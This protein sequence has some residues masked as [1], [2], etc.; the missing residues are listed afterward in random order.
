LRLSYYYP[1]TR[2][3]STVREAGRWKYHLG[4]LIFVA[5]TAVRNTSISWLVKE[6]EPLYL[7]FLSAFFAA[8]FSASVRVSNMGWRIPYKVR[9]RAP[10]FLGLGFGTLMGMAGTTLTLT[11]LSPVLTSLFDVAVYPATVGVL[12]WLLTHSETIRL[13]TLIPPLALG[14]VGIV[15]FSWHDL[16]G[17]ALAVSAGGFLWAGMAVFGWALSIV[18]ATNLLRGDTPVPDVVTFR[19]V[20]TTVGLGLYF[21]LTNGFIWH[22][23]IP[24]V[25]LVGIGIYGMPMFISFMSVRRLSVITFALYTMMTPVFT[26][27]LAG[28]FLGEKWLTGM[29]VLGALL[30]FGALVLRITLEQRRLFQARRETALTLAQT[31]TVASTDSH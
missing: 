23:Y 5:S 30:V 12:A 20:V 1:V 2:L 13:K 16:Q 15:L 19:F 11:R 28:I 17:D 26:Y 4:F 6:M 10:Y 22:R 3:T 8:L 29:Q 7:T 31:P 21:A 27:I 18:T 9:P 25:A 24:W 14:V